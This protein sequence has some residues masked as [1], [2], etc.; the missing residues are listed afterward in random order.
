MLLDANQILPGPGQYD[1]DQ[2][3]GKKT[4]VANLTNSPGWSIRK[5]T[6]RPD[7]FVTIAMYKEEQRRH[8]NAS[9]KERESTVSSVELEPSKV[10]LHRFQDF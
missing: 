7:G 1:I 6:V 2:C 5:P 3:L 9:R 10:S 4:S 8:S